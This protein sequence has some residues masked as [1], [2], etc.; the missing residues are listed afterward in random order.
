MSTMVDRA[1]WNVKK[2]VH[3]ATLIGRRVEEDADGGDVKR[4]KR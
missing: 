4:K 2:A 3:G 1:G